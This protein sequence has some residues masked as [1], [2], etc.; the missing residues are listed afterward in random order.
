M[1]LN[2]FFLGAPCVWS[3]SILFGA[4]YILLELTPQRPNPGDLFAIR[5]KNE[6]YFFVPLAYLDIR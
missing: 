3:L 4:H 2:Y 6:C 1:Y 5:R